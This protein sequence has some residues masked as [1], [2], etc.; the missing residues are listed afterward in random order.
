MSDPRQVGPQLRKSNYSPLMQ[1][2]SRRSAG[3]VVNFCPFG[4]GDHELDEAGH[5]GHLIGFYN[6]GG[7]FEPRVRRKKGQRAHEDGRI[8]VD[9]SKRQKMKGGY[10]LVRITSTARVYCAEPVKDLIV[11]RDDIDRVQEETL[12]QETELLERAE[13]I[14]NPVLEGDWGPTVYDAAPAGAAA[15]AT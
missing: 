9:G 3:E 4:C 10:K 14:R 15:A 7:T 11:R 13:A 1:A 8:I 12:R 6:G 5:C 2:L